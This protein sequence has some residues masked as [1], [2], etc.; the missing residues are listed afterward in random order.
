MVLALL[1]VV[2][3]LWGLLI[4][5]RLTDQRRRAI[6]GTLIQSLLNAD[7]SQI[8]AIIRDINAASMQRYT[9]P[10]LVEVF[11]DPATNA[12][13]KLHLSLA[14]LSVDGTQV[15][16]LFDRLLDA[17]PHE[18]PVIRDALAV[19]KDDL[20]DKLWAVVEK[21]E[22]GKESQR[23]RA[24]AALAKYDPESEKWAKANSPVMKQLVGESPVFLGL[25]MEGFRPIK[26]VAYPR[27]TPGARAEQSLDLFPERGIDQGRVLTGMDLVPI[28]DLAAVSDVGQQ[29]AQA[30]GCERL[31]APQPALAG[32]P[33]L[34][35]P[36]PPR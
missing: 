29:P 11:S 24:A 19:H 18:V 35:D 21:P 31:A 33:A 13:G 25:W 36:T 8:G 32:P 15:A 7:T 34:L 17:E 9:N 10:I 20:R 14:L 1:L 12:K 30:A 16:Y 5:E 27:T 3:V 2:A 4:H 23:L 26:G 6:A 22:K 28:T